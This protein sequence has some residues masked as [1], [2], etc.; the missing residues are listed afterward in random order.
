MTLA[1]FASFDKG[2]PV[3]R[4]AVA[5]S[6]F[7][8]LEA[9]IGAGI[10]LFRLVADD[11]SI[12]RGVSMSLHLVNTFLLLGALTVTAWWTRH[13]APARSRLGGPLAWAAGLGFLLLGFVGMTGA[14]AALGDTLFPTPSYAASHQGANANALVEETRHLFLRL[15]VWHPVVSIV[16]ALWWAV[17]AHV[18]SLRS[19]DETTRRAALVVF[20]TTVLQ[21]GLGV[22]NV[23]LRAP[24]WMQLVHLFVAN[25]IVVA[26]VVFAS[27]LLLR[28]LAPRAAWQRA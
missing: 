5:S 26:A 10:V 13:E 25:V 18:A 2:A 11:Q 1:A 7:M 12:V 20:V 22:I 4:A 19:D 3:R 14:I 6:V 17:L 28:G 23:A 21:L 15:R 16:G 27:E 8:I 9:I 24:V